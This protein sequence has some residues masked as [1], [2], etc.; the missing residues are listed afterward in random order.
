MRPPSPGR[1]GSIEATRY[2]FAHGP[3]SDLSVYPWPP[4]MHRI[5]TSP[6]GRWN[7]FVPAWRKSDLWRTTAAPLICPP[8]SRHLPKPVMGIWRRLRFPVAR[9]SPPLTAGSL[10]PTRSQGVESH[11]SDPICPQREQRAHRLSRG[12]AVKVERLVPKTLWARWGQRAPPFDRRQR[13]AK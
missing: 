6:G 5:S 4:A 10:A 11:A 2:C 7:G 12:H 8:G 1:P 13:R 3:R 9:N